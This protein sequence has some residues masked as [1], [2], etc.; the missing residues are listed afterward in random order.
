MLFHKNTQ[1][2]FRVLMIVI[3]ILIILSMIMLSVPA[4]GGY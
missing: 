1:K 2:T 4:L 3:G